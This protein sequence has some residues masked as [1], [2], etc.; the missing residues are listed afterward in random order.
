MKNK[1]VI[2]AALAVGNIM[3][4][5]LLVQGMMNYVAAS[6]TEKSIKVSNEIKKND[7]GYINII[8]KLGDS[9]IGKVTLEVRSGE[10]FISSSDLMEGFDTDVYEFEEDLQSNG[11]YDFDIKHI[12]TL[13]VKL[14]KIPPLDTSK[15]SLH[16]VNF[17]IRNVKPNEYASPLFI[18]FFDYDH[19]LELPKNLI[20]SGFKLVSRPH[21]WGNNIFADIISKDDNA[22]ETN[23]DEVVDD[24][25]KP[26]NVVF[27]DEKGA[28]FNSTKIYVTKDSSYVSSDTILSLLK[29][30]S[31]LSEYDI[32]EDINVPIKDESVVVPLKA[33]PYKDIKIKFIDNFSNEVVDLISTKVKKNSNY[34]LKE[35]VLGILNENKSKFDSYKLL[36]YNPFEID[37]NLVTVFLQKNPSPTPELIKPKPEKK[38]HTTVNFIDQSTKKGITTLNLHGKHGQKY[39]LIVP[40]G[41]DLAENESSEVTIDKSKNNINIKLVKRP[42]NVTAFRTNVTTHNLSKLYTKD[43]EVVEN[44]GLAEN[45]DWHV[46]KK[47][48][49]KGQTYYGVSTYEY[50]KASDVFEYTSINASVTT[51]DG[52]IKYLYDSKGKKV[53]NRALRPNSSWRTDKSTTINGKHAYRVS[54][55]EWL[56]SD[57]TV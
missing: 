25:F 24:I 6:S 57:D 23:P 19:E 34:I 21:S 39:S 44:R 37:D 56:L 13:V 27:T 33:M 54:T 4:S 20:P 42:K 35:Q 55:N 31:Q 53:N 43:G 28:K 52:K 15:K 46:D 38:Y 49:I 40:E 3:F 51:S 30:N 5:S 36:E 41:Y 29:Y 32:T 10:N 18:D 1:S 50:V 2:F 7:F 17:R 16:I 8:Y 11:G 9:E 22:I 26:I 12:D 47:I 48:V 45:S 14:K